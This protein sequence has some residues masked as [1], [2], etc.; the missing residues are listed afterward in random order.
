MWQ[1]LLVWFRAVLIG[2]VVSGVPTLIWGV[3]AAINL[4]F[5]ARVPWSVPIMAVVLWVYWRFLARDERRR[6]GALTAHVWR[7]SLVAG[8]TAIAA[9]WAAF[10]A[11]RGMLHIVP[12]A[13]DISRFPVWTVFAAV[14]MGSAVAGICEETGFR[15]FMQLPLERAYG[16]VTA[17]LTT[18]IIF[19][20]V[21]LSHGARIVPFLP[22]YFAA[23]IVYGFLALLTGSI[24]PGIVL[25]STGDVLMFTL[26]YLTLKAGGAGAAPSGHIE[27]IPAIVAIGLAAAS[28]FLF[29]HLAAPPPEPA[30][31]H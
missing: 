23:A 15:G 3:L 30:M 4:R 21:H 6:A 25:H 20:L 12:P 13:E 9:V 17:I 26:Q 28:V 27:P 18:G 8:G 2:L 16:P 14:I 19:T 22:F 11:L 24:R 1:R 31:S 10:A 5:T 7:L 29:R